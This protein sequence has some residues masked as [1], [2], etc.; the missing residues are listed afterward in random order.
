M[1]EKYFISIL[2]QTCIKM[3]DNKKINID[4]EICLEFVDSASME[5]CGHIN[6]N[7]FYYKD[8]LI[9]QITNHL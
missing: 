9:L 8:I 5:R 6:M 3:D 4:K 1:L 7:T 2:W